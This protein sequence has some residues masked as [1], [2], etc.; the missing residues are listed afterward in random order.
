M[1]SKDP[2]HSLNLPRSSASSFHSEFDFDRENFELEQF[3]TQ[4]GLSNT[5]QTESSLNSIQIQEDLFSSVIINKSLFSQQ[6]SKRMKPFSLKNKTSFFN[7]TRTSYQSEK[8][9]SR[10]NCKL[11]SSKNNSSNNFV[12]LLS[13]SQ[14]SGRK[15]Q[16]L[17]KLEASK[18]EYL[19]ATRLVDIY[20]K[21]TENIQNQMNV[22]YFGVTNPTTLYSELIN[23][24]SNEIL[25]SSP[26][27]SN[28]GLVHTEKKEKTEINSIIGKIHSSFDNPDGNTILHQLFELLKLETEN[29]L[30]HDIESIAD[31]KR[32]TSK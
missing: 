14:R 25:Q 27:S 18:K 23:D 6:T 15:Q 20:K 30:I 2:T 31:K 17:R 10:Q 9:N 26:R 13:N 3:M 22:D 29:N 16:L 4:S 28:S 8:L 1:R 11:L 32:L 5:H 12:S 19:Q 24:D 7:D 21:Q